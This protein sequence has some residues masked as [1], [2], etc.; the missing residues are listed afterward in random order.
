MSRAQLEEAGV[1][2]GNIEVASICTYDNPEDYY[3]YRR[4]KVTGRNATV[5]ALK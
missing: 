1:L 2:S 3:S 4:D 5:V